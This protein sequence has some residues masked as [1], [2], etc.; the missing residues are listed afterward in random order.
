MRMSNRLS[1]LRAAVMVAVL[2]VVSSVAY[3]QSGGQTTIIDDWSQIAIPPPPELRSVTVNSTTTALLILDM[4][5]NLTDP[6][7]RP[8]AAMS[9]PVISFLLSKA[10]AHSMLVVYSNTPGASP[11]D[12]VSAL[13]PLP[14]DPVVRSGVDKFYRT[15]LE[16]ILA[17][18]GI[19]TVIVT[20]TAANG[21]V[22]Y[23]ATGAALRGMK[24]IVPVDGMSAEPEY[25]EQ[26]VAWHL[27]NSPGTRNAA[28]LTRS[29]LILFTAD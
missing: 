28:T 27:L 15:D 26:Y 18:H 21:A 14:G 29:D 7:V 23:T 24:V 4:Q 9:I 13:S 1:L 16:Q 12:I 2:L 11:S 8:R 20:G 25:V 5:N 6:S 22:L 17:D 3:G 19:R 10:R